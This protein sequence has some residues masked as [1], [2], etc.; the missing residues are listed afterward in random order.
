MID[1]DKK[2]SYVLTLKH[3]AKERENVRV[4]A[5]WPSPRFPGCTGKPS[6]AYRDAPAL[7]GLVLRYPDGR[8][9]TIAAHE[10]WWNLNPPW[11]RRDDADKADRYEELFDREPDTS[12]GER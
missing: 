11:D 1:R 5:F 3:K 12:K 8:E 4:A 7:V 2:P 6:N 10:W 9:E